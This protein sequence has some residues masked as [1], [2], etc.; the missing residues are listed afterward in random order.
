MAAASAGNCP[1]DNSGPASARPETVEVTRTRTRPPAVHHPTLAP[2]APV[3]ERGDGQLQVGIDPQSAVI[4]SGPAA[5]RLL[6]A[7]DGQTPV[8][9]VIA[10]GRSAGLTRKTAAATLELLVEAG[11]VLDAQS[12]GP[13]PAWSVRLVGAGSIGREVAELLTASGVAELYVFDDNPP[14]RALYPSAGVLPCRSQALCALLDERAD[15]SAQP[16]SHWT[17]PNR[18]VDLTVVVA[19]GPEVDRIVTDHLLRTDSPH[20]LVRCLGATAV[21]GPLVRPGHTSCLH[22]HDL[23]RRDADPQWPLVLD[24]LC[25]VEVEPTPVVAAWAASAAAAQALAFLAGEPVEVESC[26]YELGA[27][28]Y[29][30]RLRAW[31]AHPECGCTW[32]GPTQWGP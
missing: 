19:D 11:L 7:L 12:P 14:D 26:T 28:D 1:G 32:L 20:L 13:A 6:A 25:R 21:V 23:A 30:V 22:C 8:G 9:D 10:A 17:R 15:V 16:V 3:I 29:A 24:Q 2:H 4:L 31:P 18:S 27:P 5:A